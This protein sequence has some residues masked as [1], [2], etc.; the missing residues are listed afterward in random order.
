MPTL[1]PRKER[2]A[3]KLMSPLHPVLP[4]VAL[5]LAENYRYIAR[6]RGY[7]NATFEAS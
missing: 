7:P 3:H 6:Y 2:A 4:L 5:K 1:F